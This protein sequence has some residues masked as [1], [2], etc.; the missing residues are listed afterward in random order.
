MARVLYGGS[1]NPPHI[2][3]CRLVLEI[4]E[5]MQHVI[6]G[7]DVIPCARPPHKDGAGLLPFD[8]R[9]EMLENCMEELGFAHVSRMEGERDTPSYTYDTLTDY[10]K[11]HPGEAVYFLVGSHDFFEIPT[12]FR[13]REL[14]SLC[15]FLLVPRGANDMSG[16]AFVARTLDEWPGATEEPCRELRDMPGARCVRLVA[17]GNGDDAR[18]DVGLV[19][20]LPL[21]WFDISASQ[22]RD[23]WLRGWHVDYLV[24]EVVRDML[25]WNS[26]DVHACWDP[27]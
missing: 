5:S 13:G 11:E 12:W 15:H 22:V 4:W 6:D 8:L 7:I 9:A 21:P 10:R 3:H 27:K 23:L 1:F 25:S 26:H 14:P 16:D 2:G 24:P 17:D 20:Y 18:N 19:H